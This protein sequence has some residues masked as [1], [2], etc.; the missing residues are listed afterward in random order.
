M[1]KGLLSGLQ[2]LCLALV[3]TSCS[4]NKDEVWEDTRT[5]GR[6][7]GKSLKSLIGKHGDSRQVEDP[8]EFYTAQGNEEFLPLEDQ[9]YGQLS[10]DSINQD[11]A[12]P[13]SQFSPGDP[14][15]GVPGIDAF[16]DTNSDPY[17]RNIFKKIHF[18]YNSSLLKGRENLEIVKNIADYLKQNPQ[19]HLFIEGHCDERGAAAFNFSLGSRRSN[20]IRNLLVKEGVSLDRVYTVSY[21]KE[22]PLVQGHD[23]E[24]WQKN[25]R[26]QFRVWSR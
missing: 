20:A 24:S 17:L 9:S 14:G 22:R 1:K 10:A 2:L 15:S 18:P 13:Q 6:Y 5:A 19:V 12:I 26:G 23:E 4:R 21:G 7:M 8:S 16:S 11:S 25:R 3:I